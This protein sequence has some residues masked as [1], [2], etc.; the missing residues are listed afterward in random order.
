M[1]YDAMV[2]SVLDNI[3]ARITE[4]MRVDELARAANYSTYHFCRVFMAHTGTPVM[5]Y[6]TRRKL[7][8]ARYDLSRGGRII[9]VAMYYGFDTHAGFTK[10]FKR[11]FG[12]PPSLCHLRVKARPPER[13]TVVSARYKNGGL[14]MTPYITVMTPFI[15]AGRTLRLKSPGVARHV[16]IPAFCFTGEYEADSDNLLDGTSDLFAKSDAIKHCEV[17][18]CYDVDPAGGEFT[19]LLGRGIFH[20]DDISK[21]APDMVSVEISGLYAVFSTQ[22]VPFEQ[23][24]K[25]AQIIEDTWDDIFTRWLPNSEFEYDETR[26]DYEFYDHRDHGWYFENKR[27]MDICIPIRQRE[28]AKARSQERGKVLWAQEMERRAQR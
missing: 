25:C 5:S 12:F 3:D 13:P 22:P 26:R 6:V 20:P 8:Y 28:D 11:C 23:H 18:M 2:Q 7:E 27:Q 15:V 9:D 24:D 4:N 14:Y 16:D 19:Y 1:E 21:I 10:A 17:S